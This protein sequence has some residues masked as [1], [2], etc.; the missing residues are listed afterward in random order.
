MTWNYIMC[1]R[2]F[3]FAKGQEAFGS[4]NQLA[5]HSQDQ[6]SPKKNIYWYETQKLPKNLIFIFIT[7]KQKQL[8]SELQ[9]IKRKQL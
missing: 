5:V 6:G 3:S 1:V 9:R 8:F 7:A 2:S 4:I